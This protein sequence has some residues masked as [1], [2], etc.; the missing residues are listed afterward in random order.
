M[1]QPVA[2]VQPLTPGIPIR[3]RMAGCAR[4]VRQ[5]TRVRLLRH[6]RN[7]SETTKKDTKHKACH[8][9]EGFE[10]LSS[11]PFTNITNAVEAS[12]EDDDSAKCR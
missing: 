8:E 2:R 1:T 9:M 6:P 7:H 12:E 3:Q 4:V 10:V 5:D 11:R